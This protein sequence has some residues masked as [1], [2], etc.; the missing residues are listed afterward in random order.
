MHHPSATIRRTTHS[1]IFSFLIAFP[2]VVASKDLKDKSELV[3]ALEE[4]GVNVGSTVWLRVPMGELPGL[5]KIVVKDADVRPKYE[6]SKSNVHLVL[7]AE[8][9]GKGDF[10]LELNPY[11]N[12]YDGPSGTVERFYLTD[13]KQLVAKWGKRVLKAI[14][15]RQVVIGMTE[16]QVTASWGQPTRINASG[17]RWGKHEQWIFGESRASYLYFENG[18]LTSWQN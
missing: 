7:I 5:S 15:E 6:W 1:V 18:R 4:N 9:E 16:D 3:R 17:G 12:F 11:T 10:I 14:S 13:P 8:V 2:F